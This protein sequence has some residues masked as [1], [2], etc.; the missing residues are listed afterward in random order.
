MKND[1]ENIKNKPECINNEPERIKNEPERIKVHLK[2]IKRGNTYYYTYKS[3]YP[4][5]PLWG[6]PIIPLWG[7]LFSHCGRDSENLPYIC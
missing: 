3:I 1:S 2:R 4:I 7:C 5:I 6:C